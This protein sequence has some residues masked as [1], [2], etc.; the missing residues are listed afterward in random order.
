MSTA[1]NTAASGPA[2]WR[3]KAVTLATELGAKALHGTEGWVLK[4]SLVPT[5]PFLPLDTFPWVER[6]EKMA[7]A[8]QAELAEV[9][10]HR[11]DL[12]NFQDI[13]IDQ[14]S[15][16][17]DDGWKTF[18]FLGYGFR[19]EANCKRCPQTAALLD[20]IPGL[21]TGF[22]SILSPGKHLPPHR[23]PWRGVVRYHLAQRRP[24]GKRARACSLTTGTPTRPGTAPTA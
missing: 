5:T 19:S 15:I 11:E 12:P 6:V 7:P 22:F 18:F 3:D 24:T 17:N 1:S 14:Q 23:G 8:V 20:S 4:H 9:L 13:S 16:S 21:V 10:S 2:A